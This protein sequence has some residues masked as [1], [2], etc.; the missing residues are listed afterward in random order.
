MMKPDVVHAPARVRRRE[1]VL[2]G[3]RH[4]LSFANAPGLRIEVLMT[5]IRASSRSAQASANAIC[6]QVPSEIRAQWHSGNART[7]RLC[8]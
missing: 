5:R 2:T 1:H 6:G 7:S 4:R 8:R 3:Q